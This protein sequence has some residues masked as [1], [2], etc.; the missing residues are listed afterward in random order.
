MKK[1]ITLLKQGYN[2]YQTNLMANFHTK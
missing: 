1:V 2:H